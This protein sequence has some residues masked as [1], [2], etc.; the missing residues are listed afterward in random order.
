MTT[1]DTH[2]LTITQNIP[3]EKKNYA[4]YIPTDLLVYRHRFIKK[5]VCNYTIPFKYFVIIP[6][7]CF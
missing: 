6:F 4:L 3:F 2:L 7:Y 5:N 1:L